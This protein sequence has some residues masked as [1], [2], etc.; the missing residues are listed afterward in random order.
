M[1]NVIILACERAH[2][3]MQLSSYFS[4]LV[5]KNNVS[6][7]FSD[8]VS[9]TWYNQA[10]NMALSSDS[11]PEELASF[12]EQSKRVFSTYNRLPCFYT[13]PATNPH[14]IS[15]LM[16][17]NDYLP[18]DEE[19]WMFYSEQEMLHANSNIEIKQV[20]ED[21]LGAFSDFYREN[22]PG[23]EVE[24]YIKCVINGFFRHPPLVDIRY[25][26][27]Y[28]GDSPVGMISILSI[29]KFAGLY[30]VAVNEKYRRRGVCR[31]M[32]SSAISL[33]NAKGIEHIFLQTGKGEESEIAFAK[34]GFKTEF[35]RVGYAHKTAIDNMQHG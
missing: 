28:K 32:I 31:T 17:K 4:T 35:V 18:F 16:E 24:E 34:M 3:L 1:E 11:T 13:S 29:G 23:P 19:A 2:Y 7:A 20:T 27:A 26:L 30:A 6:F 5:D 9:D 22:L 14:A 21:L 15:E 8:Y 33:C 25:L 10:Y 12:M